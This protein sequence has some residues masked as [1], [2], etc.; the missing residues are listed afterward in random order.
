[1]LEDTLH[2]TGVGLITFSVFIEF[3][4][5]QHAHSMVEILLAVL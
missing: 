3:N 5:T 4:L 2:S 1:M